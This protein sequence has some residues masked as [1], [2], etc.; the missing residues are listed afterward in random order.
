MS[1]E[2]MFRSDKLLALARELEC[3]VNIPGVCEG[4]QAEPAHSNQQQ[5]GKGTAIKS[6][7]CF[8]AA[9]C[10]ACHR[11]IDQGSGLSREE[12]QHYWRRGFYLTVLELWR[13]GLIR[14]A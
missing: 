7:D 11:A 1:K 6:H 9:S 5:H 8:Y 2:G 4:G 13:R 3:K 12:K 10:R 14:V